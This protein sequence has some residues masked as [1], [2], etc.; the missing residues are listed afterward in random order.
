MVNL[1][2]WTHIEAFSHLG[3]KENHSSGVGIYLKHIAGTL[4]CMETQ[5]SSLL[6]H[7]LQSN[8]CVLNTCKVTITVP[9]AEGN[10]KEEKT[11]TP[12]WRQPRFSL[13]LSNLKLKCDIFSLQKLEGTLY[14]EITF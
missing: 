4:R 7:W 12:S 6:A 3:E 9:G 14:I 1:Q 8:R 10:A 13:S 2:K 5:E 11:R